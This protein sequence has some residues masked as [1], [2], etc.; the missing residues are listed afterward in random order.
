MSR[1]AKKRSLTPDGDALIQTRVSPEAK[2][3]LDN[4]AKGQAISTAA[5]VRQ[6]LYRHL[7]LIKEH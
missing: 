2:D 5:Y 3:L 7:G 1:G 6:L 4:A